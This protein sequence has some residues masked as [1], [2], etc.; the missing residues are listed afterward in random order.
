M[1]SIATQIG[2]ATATVSFSESMSWFGIGLWGLV[3]FSA[4][5]LILT[6]LRGNN[7]ESPMYSSKD[8]KAP[9]YQQAA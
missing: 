3:L 9:A 4:G 8:S 7:S 2:I 5:G 1:W 6:A